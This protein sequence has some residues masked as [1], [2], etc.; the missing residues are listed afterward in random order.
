MG[1]TSFGVGRA[2]GE[3][4]MSGFGTSDAGGGAIV[5][6]GEA[7]VDCGA[8]WEVV[9]GLVVFDVVG[10]APFAG[11]VG[12]TTELV[13]GVVAGFLAAAA[14]AVGFLVVGDAVFE[15]GGFPVA[16]GVSDFFVVFG[17]CVVGDL[18]TPDGGVVRLVG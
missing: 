5:G 13:E 14:G 11:V 2:S 10:E 18:V 4:A 3:F 12:L 9:D 8:V 7:P 1:S 16:G 15:A 6:D 17:T